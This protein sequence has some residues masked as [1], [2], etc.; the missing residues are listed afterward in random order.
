MK[1]AEYKKCQDMYRSKRANLAQKVLSGSRI[2]VGGVLPDIDDVEK[3]Y[4]CISE[5]ESPLDDAPYGSNPSGLQNVRKPIT[6]DDIT[7]AIKSWKNSSPGPNGVTIPQVKKLPLNLFAILY[8]IF[9]SR[10]F[11][12][13]IWRSSRTVLFP[14]EDDLRDLSNWRPI[15]ISSAVQCLFHRL[16]AKRLASVV[17][18]DSQQ[19]GFRSMDGNMANIVLVDQYTRSRRLT[20]KVLNVTFLDVRKAFDSVSHHSCRRGLGRMGIDGP[21]IEYIMDTL[22]ASTTIQVGRA[23]TRHIKFRRSVKQGNPLSPILFNVVIDELKS[24]LNSERPGG[25]IGPGVLIAC[26]GFAGDLVLKEDRNLDMSTA[27]DAAL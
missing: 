5:K 24:K 25:M 23:H 1:A 7:G 4:R 21:T 15:T 13:G 19:R 27:I 26:L 17:D 3:L 14:M 11:T 2:L 8:N 9:L 18:L 20:G 16:L 10:R 22:D 12:P 6:V